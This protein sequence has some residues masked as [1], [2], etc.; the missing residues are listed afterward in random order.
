MATGRQRPLDLKEACVRAA[1]EV[2]AERG[3]EALSMRDVARKLGIS[4]QAPY[5]HFEGRD[6][7]LEVER[8]G[9]GWRIVVA[10]RW[11]GSR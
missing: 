4:H 6:H 2:I 3:I 8:L 1:R 10:E 5:R 11:H 7:L 9:H